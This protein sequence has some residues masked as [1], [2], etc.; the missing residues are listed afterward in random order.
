MLWSKACPRCLGD[1]I[2]ES[3]LYGQSVSCLQCGCILN[4]Q[5]VRGLPLSRPRV[6]RAGGQWDKAEQER[7]SPI[8]RAG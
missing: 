6:H 7:E 5:Q 3:D 4:E 8:A 1:L 2:L